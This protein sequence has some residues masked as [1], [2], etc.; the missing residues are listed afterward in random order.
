MNLLLKNARIH[1]GSGAASFRGDVLIVGNKISA[2]G[3]LPKNIAR[4]VIDCCGA[5]VAPGFIDILSESDHHLNILRHPEQKY[6]IK[7]GITSVIGGNGGISMAP[8]T[9]DSHSLFKR[10]VPI[11]GINADWRTFQ[12]FFSSLKKIKMGVHFGSFVGYE[13]LRVVVDRNNKSLTKKQFPVL[14]NL[15]EKCMAE[16]ALGLSIDPSRAKTEERAF[17]YS[18]SKLTRT[19]AIVSARHINQALIKEVIKTAESGVKIVFEGFNF[20]NLSKQELS[21]LTAGMK[22]TDNLFIAI[23]PI[24]SGDTQISMLLPEWAHEKSRKE[25]I[26]ELKDPWLRK[27]VTAELPDIDPKTTLIVHSLKHDTLVGA[28]LK[29]FMSHRGIRTSKDGLMELMR[30]TETQ[31]TLRIKRGNDSAWNEIIGLPNTIMGLRELGFYPEPWNSLRHTKGLA[32]I[33]L[34]DS[35]FGDLSA[36]ERIRKI[37]GL[38]ARLLGLKNRGVLK[39]GMSADIVV[40]NENKVSSV[41]IDGEQT[42]CDGKFNAARSG[43]IIKKTT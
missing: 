13:S 42:L 7:Q 19:P 14:K 17:V 31:S 33:I 27:K 11:G 8:L 1:D 15:A 35:I 30:V 23:E 34:D 40:I 41:F 21:E 37:T 16:G 26:R 24:G 9:A 12:E 38:P 29:E 6:L 3:S 32:E 39:E 18:I 43:K 10:Y 5:I 20:L 2:V 25:M 4:S 36:S 22:T 28:T